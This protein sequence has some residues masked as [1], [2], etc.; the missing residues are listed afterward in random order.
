MFSVVYRYFRVMSL[1]SSSKRFY[2]NSSLPKRFTLPIEGPLTYYL[3]FVFNS[4]REDKRNLNIQTENP[5][6][7]GNFNCRN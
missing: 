6:T 5:C 4:L 7:T 2:L 1:S 3:L